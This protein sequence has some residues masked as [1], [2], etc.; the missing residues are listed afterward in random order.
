MAALTARVVR[1]SCQQVPPVVG[2]AY[3]N[4]R[5]ESTAVY[6]GQSTN[7]AAYR[8]GRGGRASFSGIVATVFG[9]SGF[10]GQSV[11]NRLGKIGT[12]II[13]PYR[14][15]SYFMRDLKLAGDLGQIVFVPFELQDEE[16]IRKA[17]KYSN[18][19]VNLIGRDW[20][21][22]NYKY[23]DVNVESAARIARL[24]REMGVEKFVHFSHLNA[25]P[26]PPEILLKGGS[27]YLKTKY[28]SEQ[29]VRN[30]F[31]DAII[32]KPSDVYGA[33]DRFL[34]YYASRHVAEGVVNAIRDPEAVGK[35]FEAVGPSSYYLSDLIDYMYGLLRYDNFKRIHLTP[36]FKLKAMLLEKIMPVTPPVVVD[37]LSREH[38][39]DKTAYLPSLVDLGVKLTNFEERVPF[40]LKPY[41]KYGYYED[42]LGEFAEPQPPQPIKS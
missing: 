9:A 10:L 22:K 30:E 12:Q 7:L 34:V 6:K 27:R 26:N 20:E 31:P 41:K 3:V 21:T 19:V 23:E 42:L 35:T 38:V 37:R 33:G 29:A 15:N 18:V 14:G 24:A 28:Q 39:N 1:V 11:V 13:A 2:C 4:S 40:E 32:F 16:A 5:H 8:R 25:Q 36:E 17:M